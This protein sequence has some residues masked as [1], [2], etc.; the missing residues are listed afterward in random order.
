LY[1]PLKYGKQDFYLE[2]GLLHQTALHLTFTAA[3]SPT[4]A[5]PTAAESPTT[6]ESA[7]AESPTTAESAAAESPTTAEPSAAESPTTAEPSATAESARVRKYQTVS[8]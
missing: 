2:L 1:V 7:A 3:E 4:T 5:E 6:A 8:M